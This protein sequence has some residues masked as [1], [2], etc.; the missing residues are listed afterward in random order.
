MS[1]PTATEC[2][3]QLG[4]YSCSLD[5]K[6][7]SYAKYLNKYYEGFLTE[8]RPD[9]RIEVDLTSNGKPVTLPNSILLSKKVDSINFNY[10]DGLIIGIFDPDD[11]CCRITVKDALFSRIR[12]FE[13]FLFQTTYTLL[14]SNKDS[15]TFLMHGCAVE[16]DEMGFLFTGP[17]ES[18]KSTVARLSGDYNVLGD[19]IIMLQKGEE[20][21]RLRSTPFRGDY[22]DNLNIQAPLKAVFLL[23]QSASNR[24]ADLN[25][26]EFVTRFLKEVI[27]PGTI[28]S[29]GR[30]AEFEETLAFSQAIAD[31]VPFYELQFRPERELW[32]PI[33]DMFNIKD[34]R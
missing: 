18:G 24:L 28:L 34:K 27:Y 7:E 29:D 19:E 31:A 22:R 2:R 9:I 32:A 8:E 3:I 13:H 20:G 10:H 5:M 16:R 12:I 15:T 11:K 14:R 23:K 1:M 6:R 17:S 30:K 21:Y 25:K 26:R 4:D 33:E